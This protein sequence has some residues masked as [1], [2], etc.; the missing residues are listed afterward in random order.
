[1]KKAL[2]TG[3]TGQD[4]AYLSKFLLSKGY[5]VYGTY[6]RISTPNFWRLEY[7]GIKNEVELI[8]FDL[9]D[10]PSII[11]AILKAQPDEIYNL[12]AQS[13]VEASFDQPVATGSITGLSVTRFL[14]VIRQI[15]PET[16]FYQASTSEMFGNAKISPQNE[17]TPFHPESPYA[18]AKLYAHWIT[19]NYSQSYGLFA[20]SGILFNHESPIRGEE[21]VTR[22]ITSGIAKIKA[23][24]IP[25]IE[26]GNLD[27]KRDWGYAMDFVECMWLILQHNSPDSFVI[28]TGE[29]HSVRD[30]VEEAFK[31]AGFKIRW[32][33]KGKE[34]EGIDINSGKILVKVNPK[35]FRPR[36]IYVLL[37]D[38][39]KAIEHLK[40]NPKKTS[41]EKLVDIMVEADLKREI[42]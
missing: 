10:E 19:L 12:A 29:N 41:F 5:K 17:N 32:Q 15:K 39:Q 36:D 18:I 35:Y 25:F 31:R 24:K 8:P 3:V 40:W 38:P 14:D 13:F 37:G 28:A 27:A 1:M 16:K 26:V 7:L 21:F 30:F 2:I 34:E 11:S 9:I 33:G 22:K 42:I 23:G 4:G 20:A 6:R